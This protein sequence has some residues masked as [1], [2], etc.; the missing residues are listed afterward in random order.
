MPPARVSGLRPEAAKRLLG[1]NER[2]ESPP[3]MDRWPTLHAVP[4]GSHRVSIPP[5]QVSGTWQI[6]SLYAT[7]LSLASLLRG[8]RDLGSGRCQ[9]W[10]LTWLSKLAYS[11]GFNRCT[12]VHRKLLCP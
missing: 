3:A 8:K 9:K 12:Q 6:Q 2:Q 10:R 7:L 4:G 11:L 5:A 1:V